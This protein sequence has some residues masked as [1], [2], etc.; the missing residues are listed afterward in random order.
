MR[1]AAVADADHIAQLLLDIGW[2]S[3]LKGKSHAE[4]SSIVASHLSNS[5]TETTTTVA[6]VD[7]V[8][9]G[10]SNTHWL[11]DLFMPAPEGYVSEV[12]VSPSH[13]GLGIGKALLTSI[14]A[15]GKRR[16][17]YRLSLINGKH[18]DSYQ[19]NFYQKQGWEE[20]DLMANFV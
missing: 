2:F 19:R 18:R 4:I 17:A 20:R 11:H 3:G 5:S 12:F 14:V 6:I 13:Q 15:E 1:A 16:G 7:E 9:R 10:Y 8:V